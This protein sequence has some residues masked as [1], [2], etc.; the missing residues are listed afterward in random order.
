H[1]S[2]LPAIVTQ[3]PLSNRKHEAFAQRV[4]T[5]MPAYE[6]YSQTIGGKGNALHAAASR[7]LKK[8]K[9]RVA[10]IQAGQKLKEAHLTIEEKRDFFADVKRTAIADIDEHSPLCQSVQYFY[11]AEGN[12]SSKKFKIIDKLKAIEMDSQIS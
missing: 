9:Q 2:E 5:G 8:V 3:R 6:A 10:T 4:A 11:D 7:L 12:V 1:M